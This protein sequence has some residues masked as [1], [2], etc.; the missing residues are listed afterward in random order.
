MGTSLVTARPTTIVRSG[1]RSIDCSPVVLSSLNTSGKYRRRDADQSRAFARA[2]ARSTA[3]ALASVSSNSR[4]GS[5]SATLLRLELVDD[6]HG[7][8][9]RRARDRACGEAGLEDVERVVALPQLPSHLAHQ[10]LH[11]GIALDREEVRDAHAAKARHPAHVVPPQVHEHHVLGALLL[12]GEELL[13]ER[14]VVLARAP[15]GARAGDRPHRDFATFHSHEHLGRTAHEGAVVERQVEQVRRGIQ[16][17]EIAIQE[18]GIHGTEH[19]LTTRQ[20]RLERVPRL[21]VLE[22]A[23]DVTLERFS[24][25]A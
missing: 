19:L 17:A 14:L 21:D 11:V 1:C 25:V 6:L 15:A 20:H 9:L 10:V 7:A 16:R 24:W 3:W 2:R 8:D 5:E 4:A 18:Q 13:G 22:Y 23:R 12:I